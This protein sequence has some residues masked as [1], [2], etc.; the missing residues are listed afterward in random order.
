MC[1]IAGNVSFA[2]RRLDPE[3]IGRMT[4]A[5]AHRGPDGEGIERP[6]HAHFGHRRLAIRDLSDAGRQPAFDPTGHV[7]V[8]FNGEIYNDAQLREEISK[9]TGY[10]FRTRCDTEVLPVGWK[11]WG[12]GLFER[13]E[14]MFAIALWDA[15]QQELVLARDRVGIKPLYFAKRESSVLFAS[16]VKGILASRLV[17]DVVD[18]AA[19]HA[20]LASGYPDPETSLVRGVRQVAPGSCLTLSRTGERQHRYWAPRRQ[21]TITDPNKARDSVHAALAASCASLLL[22]DVPVGLM[23]SSGI[24]SAVIAMLLSGRSIPAFTARFTDA[25]FDEGSGAERIAA[26]AG[27]PWFPI[28][29]I[30]DAR[31]E[32]DFRAVANAVDGELADSSTLAHYSLCRALRRKV[33]V[34]MAGDGADEFFAGYPTYA[35][36]RAAHSW[37]SFFPKALANGAA[38]ILAS[39]SAHREDR[40]PKGAMIARLLAGLGAAE[41]NP[42]AEWRRL[43]PRHLLPILYGEAMHGVASKDALSVYRRAFEQADGNPL[44]RGMIA[45]QTHYL[46]GD[47]LA[48]VDR[49]SMAHGLEIRVPYLERNVMEIAGNISS[50]IHMPSFSPSKPVLRDLARALGAP[51]EIIDRPKRGFNVPIAR[52]L[53]HE[54]RDMGNRFLHDE[55]DVFSPLLNADGIRRL[56]QEHS[57]HVADHSYV[58]WALLVHGVARAD[59]T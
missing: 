37:L 34:A 16:E 28:P 56:W 47:M 5:L 31:I 42:H 45:D 36:T 12:I 9:Q 44:D 19:M 53:R 17:P 4:R 11:L 48:K 32:D 35:A 54:L 26:A 24:D 6:D 52:L 39:A 10:V 25:T 20:Y 46:P 33:T 59:R 38:R 1:G 14:G 7:M 22:S 3:V 27:S 2:D 23:L 43:T 51:R 40:L 49:M 57:D 55:L 18:P 21:A 8:T 58:L 30:G 15:E 41:G 50:R 13:L 29:A